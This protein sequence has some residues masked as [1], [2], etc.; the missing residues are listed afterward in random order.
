MQCE[1][2]ASVS[3]GPCVG[4]RC[5][6]TATLRENPELCKV[7]RSGGPSILGVH[8]EGPRSFLKAPKGSKPWPRLQFE[9]D[10]SEDLETL[11]L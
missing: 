4:C 6:G 11:V 2:A 8:D 9:L 1:L 7:K 5:L 10:P 3:W